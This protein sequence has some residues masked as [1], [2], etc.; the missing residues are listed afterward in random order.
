[1]IKILA[2]EAKAFSSKE[3]IIFDLDDTLTESKTSLSQEMASLL[4]C[5][6]KKRKVMVIGGGNLSQFMEQFVK[7]L[8]CPAQGLGNLFIAPTSGASMYENKD[9]VWKEIYR[10]ALTLQEK[11]KVLSAFKSSIQDIRYGKP[12]KIYGQIIEDRK[13][14]ITFSALGQK[15]PLKAKEKWNKE[16]DIRKVLKG[17]LERY[18][19]EFEVRLGGLTSVDITKKGIDKAYGVRFLSNLLGIPIE[20]MIYVGDALYEGGNDEVVKKTGISTLQVEGF[21]DTKVFIRT[22]LSFL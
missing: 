2:G 16:S 1:M 22:I 14:Q 10:R 4:C 12:K 13:S 5:L 19:P 3:A 9:G 15:A 21:E 17:T 7:H 8:D 6:L 20:A 11:R 18:L